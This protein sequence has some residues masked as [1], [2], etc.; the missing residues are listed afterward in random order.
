MISTVQSKGKPRR[1]KYCIWQ[2]HRKGETAGMAWEDSKRFMIPDSQ[3]FMH[4]LQYT[5]IYVQYEPC[6]YSTLCTQNK[7]SFSLLASTIETCVCHEVLQEPATRGRHLRSGMGPVLD[8]LQNAQGKTESGNCRTFQAK[9]R[10]IREPGCVRW[11]FCWNSELLNAIW[12]FRFQTI[13]WILF[14]TSLSLFYLLKCCTRNL[15]ESFAISF[16]AR[17]SPLPS[18]T[19]LVEIF[20]L[21]IFF[22]DRNI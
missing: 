12:R 8:E 19:A 4:L 9:D 13:Y 21:R 14:F 22:C 15:L 11:Y 17:C 6:T 7:K 18:S 10:F 3:I 20:S 2:A 1:S 16:F 5:R